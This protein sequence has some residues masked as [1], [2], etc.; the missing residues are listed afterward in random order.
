[1]S[2]SIADASAAAERRGHYFKRFIDWDLKAK[3]GIW[4]GPSSSSLS[5]SSLELSDTQVYEP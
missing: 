4:P 5:L 3:A 2:V 1:M